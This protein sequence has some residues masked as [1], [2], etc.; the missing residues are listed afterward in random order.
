MLNIGNIGIL[1]VLI[2]IFVIFSLIFCIIFEYSGKI[3]E[4]L[5]RTRQDFFVGWKS[6]VVVS[7]YFNLALKHDQVRAIYYNPKTHQMTITFIDNTSLN[8]DVLYDEVW[9]QSAEKSKQEILKRRGQEV[10]KL[11]DAFA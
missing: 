4:L 3:Y 8:C 1:V 9:M 2:G 11:L 7:D 6:R 5:N 10:A